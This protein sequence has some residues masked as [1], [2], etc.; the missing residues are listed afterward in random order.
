MRRCALMLGTPRST[1]ELARMHG[2]C[3]ARRLSM[4]P[5]E[6]GACMW[7]DARGAGTAI[8]M[9][10]QEPTYSCRKRCVT[11]APCF[12]PVLYRELYTRSAWLEYAT[13]NPGRRWPRLP[14][15]IAP[16]GT[17]DVG[18]GRKQPGSV[19]NC[20][21][22]R[23]IVSDCFYQWKRQLERVK[24]QCS[25]IRRRAL[26]VPP[27]PYGRGG[28]PSSPP[29]VISAAPTTLTLAKAAPYE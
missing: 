14:L 9:E 4:R 10:R 19:D 25:Q 18:R 3:A 8:S 20:R 5:G 7:N 27:S 22:R 1:A 13:Q 17:D 26:G 15:R 29:A 12:R 28:R 23:S 2:L 6:G 24:R 11:R 16:A 21:G